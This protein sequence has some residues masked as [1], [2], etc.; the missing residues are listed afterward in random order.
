M[1]RPNQ[2]GHLKGFHY[3]LARKIPIRGKR[4]GGDR[5]R[6]KAVR[7][8]RLPPVFLNYGS[9]SLL[10]LVCGSRDLLGYAHVA[11]YGPTCPPIRTPFARFALACQAELKIGDH[12]FKLSHF[13]QELRH[14]L[15]QLPAQAAT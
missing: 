1:A 14:K 3:Q 7:P 11:C 10:I 9:G 2:A 4:A 13:A 15:L 6:Q 5:G 12:P 8:R